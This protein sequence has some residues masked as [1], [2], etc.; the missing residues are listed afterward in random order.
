MAIAGGMSDEA[1]L[2]WV[3]ETRTSS[4]GEPAVNRAE[5]FKRADAMLAQAFWQVA[6]KSNE[7]V[8]FDI[9]AKRIE[10]RRNSGE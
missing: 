3:E 4:F 5:R 2:P 9:S 1:K 8:R 10:I 6:N 7:T